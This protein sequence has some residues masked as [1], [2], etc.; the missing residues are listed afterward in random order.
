MIITI[1]GLTGTGKDTLGEELEKLLGFRRVS[2]TFKDLAKKEG[3][4]LIDFQKKAEKDKMID[5]KFD[6]YLKEETSKHDSIV[7]TWL[8]PWILDAD[9]KVYLFAPKKIRAKRVAQRDRITVEKA[10]TH[11]DEKEKQN[12]TRY[13]KVYG[14]DILD[15]SNFD[16]CLNSAKYK[17][18]ELAKIVV[19]AIQLIR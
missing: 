9:L 19:N 13:L 16:I 5:I 1:S 3:M 18:S 11:I 17:P 6:D 2:P 7:T 14:I 12:R 15:T 10:L 4:T 8:G